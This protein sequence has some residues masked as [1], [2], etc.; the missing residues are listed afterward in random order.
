M[1]LLT[2][3]ERAQTAEW[4]AGR[5]MRD[6][7]IPWLPGRKTDAWNHTQAAMGLA[8]FGHMDRAHAAF[9]FLAATQD[10]LG[11]WPSSFTPVVIIDPARDTNHT[12]YIATGLWYLHT[13]TD[14]SDFLGEMWPTMERAIDFV[15]AQQDHETG[16][17]WWAVD[18]RGATWRAPLLAG[19]A[20]AH[21]SLLCAERIAAHLGY[22]RPQWT[23]AR[24]KLAAALRR[25]D[26]IFTKSPRS[27]AHFS[28]DWYYPVLGGAVR[29]EAARERIRQ[30]RDQFIGEGMGCRC[31]RDRPW[32]TVAETCELVMALDACGYTDHARA[33]LH[34]TRS[35]R[36][37][38][39]GYWMGIA[40]P[41]DLYWPPERPAWTAATVLLATDVIEA[42][43]P[44]SRF[45]R[46]L[47]AD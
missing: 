30:G 12:A 13:L 18:E 44:T 8:L 29:G 11:S 28:M 42:Q 40:F 19:S 14:H 22:E 21:G 37:D 45:F 16:A 6:G 1:R 43:S 39:G 3:A 26:V 47:A 38:D 5:Q 34:W 33:L 20:S 25:D 23:R 35:L 27:T 41:D 4:I 31:V 24:R 9:R 15:V 7:S 32:Y 36:G 10:E 46:D 17:L 2:T